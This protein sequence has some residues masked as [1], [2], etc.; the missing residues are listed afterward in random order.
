[1]KNIRIIL[2]SVIML[3]SIFL[4]SAVAQGGF[5]EWGFNFNVRIFNGLLGDADSNEDDDS[6]TLR[7]EGTVSF[8]Y[9]DADGDFHEVLFDVAGAHLVMRWSEGLDPGGPDEIGTWL[10]YLVEGTGKIYDIPVSGEII[11][12]IIYEGHLTIFYKTQKVSEDEYPITQLVISGQG[13]VVLYVPPGFG[14]YPFPK[15]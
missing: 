14:A 7:G 12:E 5:D 8:G 15:E 6:D 4:I 10:T 9:F 1:M 3:L 13:I 2:I 11:G